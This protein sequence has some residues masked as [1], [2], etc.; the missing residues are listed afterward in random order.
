[1][2]RGLVGIFVGLILAVTPVFAQE[3]V[4]NTNPNPVQAG[5]SI[6]IA[7]MLDI[8]P[9]DIFIKLEGETSLK[10][11]VRVTN[12]LYELKFKVPKSTKLG[13]KSG[14][15]LVR[16]KKGEVLRLP[17]NFKVVKSMA[18]LN[19]KNGAEFQKKEIRH[20]SKH[21]DL[22]IKIDELESK[23]NRME[24]DKRD[25]N[26]K[27]NSLNKQLAA[28]R[29]SKKKDDLFR[30]RE[31]E[32]ALLT[33]QLIDQQRQ[34]SATKGIL[35]EKFQ[36]VSKAE[37][38]NLER[39]II[40]QQMKEN[41]EARRGTVDR[42]SKDVAMEKKLIQQKE[43][44][45]IEK[46]KSLSDL[47]SEISSKQSTLQVMVINLEKEESNLSNRKTRLDSDRK[48][49]VSKGAVVA[50]L[51]REV[52]S[53]RENLVRMSVSL[54]NKREK[55]GR[56]KMAFYSL[57]QTERGKF[58]RQRKLLASRRDELIRMEKAIMSGE[59]TLVKL[60]DTQR[61]KQSRLNSDNDAFLRKQKAWSVKERKLANERIAVDGLMDE[62]LIKYD[63]LQTLKAWIQQ[64]L[65][66]LQEAY[67]QSNQKNSEYISS[68]DQRFEKLNSL[69]RLIEK[70]ANNLKTLNSD[71]DSKNRRL[72]AELDEYLRPKYRFAFS[73]YVGFRFFDQ[74]T[75]LT[76]AVDLGFRGLM[77]LNKN[78]SLQGGLGIVSTTRQDA[79]TGTKA[80]SYR[81]FN[82]NVLYDM[83]PGEQA[84]LYFLTGLEGDVSLNQNGVRVMGGAGMRFFSEE[85]LSTVFEVRIGRDLVTSFGFEKRIGTSLPT[86]GSRDQTA[87]VFAAKSVQ[88]KVDVEVGISRVSTRNVYHFETRSFPD[89]AEKHW[90]HKH[91]LVLQ[92]TGVGFGFLESKIKFEP[93][94]HVT[95]S[96]AASMI[97]LAA[98]V[99]A[100][101]PRRKTPISY[102]L[103]G[104]PGQNY[105][106]DL[107]IVDEKGGVVRRL[108]QKEKQH[109]G[110]HRFGWDGAGDSGQLVGEG[111]Y[112]LRMDV[113]V[114][115]VKES[116]EKR[117]DAYH[118]MVAHQATNLTVVNAAAP[119][120]AEG[121]I[122]GVYADVSQATQSYVWVN[123]S[124]GMKVF[125][126]RYQGGGVGER[127]GE[128][129]YFG[130][131][132]QLTRAEFMI[133]VS[134]AML[135]L[136]AHK[137]RMIADLSPY[138]DWNAIPNDLKP[139]LNLYIA[140]LGYG[141]DQ[142]SR[143]Y[144]NRLVTRAEAVVIIR[145]FIDWVNRNSP[146]ALAYR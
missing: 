127:K 48:A 123:K 54:A 23:L 65:G 55:L 69:T 77:F 15:I 41:L 122:Q 8:D 9:S 61:H 37:Q 124:V 91:L 59:K 115:D 94:R 71:L 141:G 27:I 101:A 135:H 62:I 57:K 5:D 29:K 44:R 63:I 81:L 139:F 2:G 51:D 111:Q 136:G 85:D 80:A 38:E 103:I 30:K 95:R 121:D 11:M 36:E 31:Q 43:I 33:A 56:Q 140:E 134:K 133:A 118:R 73:P 35:R 17:V 105:Y 106:L 20:L 78:W 67:R 53:K 34:M 90:A 131:D 93:K 25:L 143:L 58:E 4:V 28:Q 16:T 21:A 104:Q 108:L 145:R 114:N 47:E 45:L 19:F 144:P 3:V 102:S 10:S 126:P 22:N 64:K 107:V 112:S 82:L 49:I 50:K 100:L 52:K 113:F 18:D 60:E 88:E 26:K 72:D 97:V 117:F 87:A 132:D 86:Q 79:I 83:N 125:E 138:Q 142:H 99:Q 92:K 146:G 24:K 110:D 75:D 76:S 7:V 40:L 98:N 84:R 42:Q 137:K 70:R 14:Q 89:L 32:L 13:R 66:N 6:R 120:L 119:Q 46:G 68:F 39:E 116:S 12:Q 130:K 1:M 129:A 96:E 74:P 128:V 109:S